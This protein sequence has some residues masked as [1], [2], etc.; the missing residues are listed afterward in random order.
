[1]KK[2]IILAMTLILAASAV[3][4]VMAAEEEERR[5]RTVFETDTFT[6]REGDYLSV[7]DGNIREY[8]N[9]IGRAHV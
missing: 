9:E 1:M 3:M 4:P 8:K 6:A 5:E 2:I 7:Y